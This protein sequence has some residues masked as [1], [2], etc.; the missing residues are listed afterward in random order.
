MLISRNSK[1]FGDNFKI[2][3]FFVFFQLFCMNLNSSLLIFLF[4]K[5]YYVIFHKKFGIVRLFT[6]LLCF[7]YFQ[8][9]E[10]IKSVF[11]YNNS[12]HNI[13]IFMML[14]NSFTCIILYLAAKSY[15]PQNNYDSFFIIA[16]L[17]IIQALFG[18]FH[19]SVREPEFYMY[20]FYKVGPNPKKTKALHFRRSLKI[21]IEIDII[22][23]IMF[24][25]VRLTFYKKNSFY[26]SISAFILSMI[27][28]LI[29]LKDINKENKKQ[30][31]IA[32]FA[33]VFEIFLH[34]YYECSALYK[35]WTRRYNFCFFIA[36][37]VITILIVINLL[38]LYYN[39]KDYK[40]YGL[41]LKK[42]QSLSNRKFQ[43]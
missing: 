4:V 28:D 32:I 17:Y 40:C 15:K 7:N 13:S 24:V 33:N 16:F 31:R 3:M 11:E 18:F 5:P 30:K 29:S 6:I 42:I 37:Y 20:L 8:T 36:P 12:G 14:L 25:I 2:N 43:L 39:Y 21:M 9:Y 38:V 10:Y 34:I 23:N 19:K 1:T 22:I 26:F 35:F 27:T 41:G